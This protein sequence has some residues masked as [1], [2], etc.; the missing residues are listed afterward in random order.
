MTRTLT[1][2]AIAALAGLLPCA[3]FATEGG[4]TS[5]PNG[6]ED[7]LVAAM[8]PPGIY[9]IVYATR[10]S[11]DRLAGPSGDLPLDRF[12]LRVNAI[13][14]RL[15]WVKPATW[16]G[17]DRW[18]T[19]LILPYLDINLALS[20]AP[21]VQLAASRRGLGDLTFGNG[22]HWTLGDF[23]MVNAID[24][25]APTGSYSAS[26][27]V[28]AG[29]NQWV[30]RANHM[31]TWLTAHWDFSY[32]I[33]HDYNFENPDTGYR[34]GQTVYLN[35]AFG[36]KATPATTIGMT[37]YVLRQITDDH[38]PDAPR[39]GNRLGSRGIGPAL[40]HF[41]PGGVFVTAKYLREQ[42]ARNGPR[43]EQFWLYLGFPLSARP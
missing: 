5:F 14:P 29:R 34:S 36:W 8:P 35:Y 9:S 24:V 15:D 13:T 33:H 11:A 26:R 17:A 1:I 6:G 2:R 28:N 41:F 31:G 30:G 20:P 43:G 3:A 19:L 16:L 21:G 12:R 22:L 38:G 39:D 37:G 23:Q 18:G 42:S 40:K 4:T 32:R 25:V 7:F 27:L 10:Y